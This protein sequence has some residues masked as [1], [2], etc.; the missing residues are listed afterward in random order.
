LEF[1]IQEEKKRIKIIDRVRREK[2]DEAKILGIGHGNREAGRKTSPRGVKI[3]C[4]L[5]VI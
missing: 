5:R 2:S 1:A 4:V 3:E